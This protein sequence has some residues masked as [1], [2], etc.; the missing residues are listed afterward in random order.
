MFTNYMIDALKQCFL[1]WITWHYC[2]KLV[3]TITGFVGFIIGICF[4]CYLAKR[5]LDNAEKS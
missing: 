2:C 3:T 1:D 4:I 5:G